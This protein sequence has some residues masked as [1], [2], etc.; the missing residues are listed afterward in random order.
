MIRPIIITLIAIMFASCNSYK[1]LTYLQNIG[2]PPDTLY[3]KTKLPY[4]LQPA[5]ILYV[6]IITLDEPTNRLFNPLYGTGTNMTQMREGSMYLFGYEVDG[7]GNIELPILHKI[8]VSGLTVNEAKEKI[9]K[10][11]EEYLNEAMTIVKLSTFKFSILGEV[12]SPGVK[13]FG[14]FQISLMEALAL[15]GD[16][17][18]NGNRENILILRAS[19]DNNKA[20]RI[21]VTDKNLVNSEFYYIQPNDVIY[22]EPLKTTLFRERTAD[23]LYYVTAFTSVI[24]TLLLIISFL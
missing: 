4:L 22:V 23:Y 9:Q 15:G 12:K 8:H 7:S 10:L 13:E 11:A 3:T 16:I 1:K 18:Y 19:K 20:Y 14:A 21:D 24:T 2:T 6:R 17:T 5:D